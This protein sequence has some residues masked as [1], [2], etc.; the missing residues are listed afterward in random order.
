MKNVSAVEKNLPP[1]TAMPS[2]ARESPPAPRP[3]AIGR[4]PTMVASAV[5]RIGR[6]RVF[7]ACVTASTSGSPR[8]RS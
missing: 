5:I 2:G 8:S 3:R 4:M 7:D 6:K 1:S